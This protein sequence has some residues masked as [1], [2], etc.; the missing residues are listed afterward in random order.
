M[1]IGCVNML[2][3]K[4]E[5]SIMLDFYGKLLTDKQLEIMELYYNQDLSLTEIA[6]NLGVT[7]QAVHDTIKKSEKSLSEYENKL[8][9]VAGLGEKIKLFGKIENL[10]LEFEGIL[11]DKDVKQE[12]KDKCFIKL[13][14]LIGQVITLTN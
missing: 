9:L 13:S 2:E 1:L 4:V 12:E 7:R 5:V 11:K 3:K 6:E 10:C 14:K 8:H